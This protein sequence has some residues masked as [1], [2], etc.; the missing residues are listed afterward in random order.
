MSR[1]R[2]TITSCSAA[3]RRVQHCGSNEF[4]AVGSEVCSLGCQEPLLVTCSAA[5]QNSGCQPRPICT[6]LIQLVHPLKQ[7]V[8]PLA[9]SQAAGCE[10]KL[11][12]VHAACSS[13]LCRTHHA[14]CWAYTS[15]SQGQLTRGSRKHRPQDQTPFPAIPVAVAEVLGSQ[16]SGR[17]DSQTNC[18]ENS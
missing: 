1:S 13:M 11:G 3:V 4:P 16:T 17:A 5:G 6:R 7:P 8:A 12:P 2:D 14:C 10:E 18:V 15:G 9:A